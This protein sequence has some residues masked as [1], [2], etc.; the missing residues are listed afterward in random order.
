MT[1]KSL[2][3][4]AQVVVFGLVLG[5]SSTAYAD[6]LAITQ[7]SVTNLTFNPATGTAVFTPTATSVRANATN[8]FG[9]TVDNVTNAFPFAQT[10]AAVPFAT[11][12]GTAATIN[13]GT[14]NGITL[15]MVQG[16]S[17]TG[18]SFAISNFTGTL[19]ILGVEG[20]VNVTISGMVNLLRDVETDQFGVLAESETV[21]DIFVNGIS[22]F[23]TESLLPLSGPNLKAVVDGVNQLSRTITLQG[24]AV[25]TVNF[26]LFTRSLAVTNEV[27]EPA[28]VLLLVSGLGFMTGVLKR[29]RKN[30]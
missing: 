1:F 25:N 2:K 6:T 18:A 13:N 23:Q 22:I 4:F 10:G 14:V 9:Q 27:P 19:V 29:K 20:N 21:F 7:F 30:G 15:A 8:S 28:T 12:F 24:G 11:A 16:C 3:V 5:A 26:R 17:C